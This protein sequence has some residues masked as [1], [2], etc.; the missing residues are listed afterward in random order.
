METSTTS[1][2]SYITSPPPST[3]HHQFHQS[4]PHPSRSSIT[5]LYDLLADLDEHQ[6]TY[7]IQEMNHTAP[8]N[9]A[10]SQA[11]SAIESDNPSDSLCTA[12]ANMQ[13]PAMSRT[14]SKSQRIR[15][16]LQTIFRAPTGRQHRQQ[17]SQD[18]IDDGT[19]IATLE[20][21]TPTSST[22]K[23]PAYKR[24]S[25]PTFNL[26]PGVTVSDLLNLLEA[27][28]LYNNA[29]AT[30]TSTSSSSQLSPSSSSFSPSSSF[31]SSPSPVSIISTSHRSISGSASA[32]GRIRRYPSTIDMALE[33]ERSASLGSVEGIGLGMLE[34]RPTTPA[35]GT[36][37]RDTPTRGIE[38]LGRTR[39]SSPST[40]VFERRLRGETPPPPLPASAS[41]SVA[42]PV[43]L[44]GI[45]EVLE[46]R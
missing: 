46:N 40:P 14:L 2:S 7:L 31:S 17:R 42:P 22:R 23:S 5:S 10:V 6:L 28:F 30:G 4:Q 45:F 34:P 25:R 29:N 24:I 38:G 16:S 32:S 20:A 21:T 44:D 11:I 9:M 1:F 12:R 35:L 27:E 37:T 39:S 18:D 13:Q 41:A 15:L 8:Q 36:P 43:V 33:A 3:T 26:P 19:G